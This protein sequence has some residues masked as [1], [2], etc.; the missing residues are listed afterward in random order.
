MVM[1]KLILSTLIVLGAIAS[2]QAQ[3]FDFG[4]IDGISESELPFDPDQ[5]LEFE[6]QETMDL[7]TAGFS[8]GRQV[9]GSEVFPDINHYVYQRVPERVT[10]DALSANEYRVGILLRN[11]VESLIT[12]PTFE[13]AFYAAQVGIHMITPP[14][15]SAS[16]EAEL[17]A[18][19]FTVTDHGF[20]LAYITNDGYEAQADIVVFGTGFN[21]G[22]VGESIA[23]VF[24]HTFEEALAAALVI[25]NP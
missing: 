18:L 1:K 6:E 16:Q 5:A 2:T 17:A 11:K 3:S 19:F 15:F 22:D 13:R 25:A 23:N 21:V 12:Y 20:N 9:H 4:C 10:I 7:A 14:S 24:Y 8:Q